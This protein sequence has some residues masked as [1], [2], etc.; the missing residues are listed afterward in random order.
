[1]QRDKL[2]IGREVK[3]TGIFQ[4]N[5]DNYQRS[6]TRNEQWFSLLLLSATA[7]ES[8]SRLKLYRGASFGNR[9]FIIRFYT[10]KDR[11]EEYEK[12]AAE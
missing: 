6:F 10:T 9:L 1:M 8:N 2:E 4:V 3:G 5:N 7:M 12:T 11:I